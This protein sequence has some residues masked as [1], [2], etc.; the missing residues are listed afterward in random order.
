MKLQKI[1]YKQKDIICYLLLLVPAAVIFSIVVILPIAKGV[2][3]SF[4][5]YKLANLDNP[6]WN[7]F[8][9]YKN[10]FKDAEVFIYLKNTIIYVFSTVVIQFL[11]GMMIALLMNKEIR[12]RGLFR[13]IFMIPWTIP[14]VVV[15]ILWRWMLQEQF[16]VINYLLYFFHFTESVNISWIQDTSLAMVS[17][18]IA[19]VWR[20]LPYTMVMLLAGLQSVDNN[21]IEAATIEGANKYQIFSNVTIPFIR[22]VMYAAIWISVL[23]NFQMFTIVYNMTGGGPIE[24]TTTLSLAT[25]KRA[26]TSYN[27]GEASAIGV[28]WMII[29]IGATI[30]YNKLSSKNETI[31]Q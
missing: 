10:I 4:C 21:L 2:S 18:I 3:V 13:G 1:N 22:P 27:F 7:S 31:Y 8:G 19:A 14:S 29:L 28:I 30:Y 5:E 23:D 15:A 9:N 24:A 16:G 11:I 25:Y 6:T 26:F 20:Q 12:Y 17:V